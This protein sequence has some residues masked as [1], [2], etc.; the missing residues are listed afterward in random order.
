N[1]QKTSSPISFFLFLN[2]NFGHFFNHFLMI[3]SSHWAYLKE[4]SKM[5]AYQD[6][7]AK[8]EQELQ[9]IQSRSKEQLNSYT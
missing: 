9:H 5:Q 4:A 8:E 2:N 1:K 7:K 6:I 3:L